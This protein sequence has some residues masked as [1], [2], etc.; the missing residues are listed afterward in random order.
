MVT[1]IMIFSCLP[2][3][4]VLEIVYGPG[5]LGA[6]CVVCL[7]G[8]PLSLTPEVALF[9][10]A[11]ATV[12]LQIR[13]SIRPLG[14]PDGSGGPCFA[15]AV[16]SWLRNAPFFHS[17]SIVRSFFVCRGLSGFDTGIVW[18]HPDPWVLGPVVSVQAAVPAVGEPGAPKIVVRF[19]ALMF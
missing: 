13:T 12:L 7:R 1:L 14:M 16:G 19:A 9:P 4:S 15:L 11:L 5:G 3:G 6:V 8:L 17:Y 2:Y 18:S 10:P